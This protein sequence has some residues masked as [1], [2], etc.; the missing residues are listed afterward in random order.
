MILSVSS[1]KYGCGWLEAG[2]FQSFCY[3]YLPV[4]PGFAIFC[5]KARGKKKIEKYESHSWYGV[6]FLCSQSTNF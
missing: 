6:A 1:S 4:V 5:I 3:L 2:I